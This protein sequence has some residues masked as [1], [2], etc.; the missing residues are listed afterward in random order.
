M[1]FTLPNGKT[2]FGGLAGQASGD[3]TPQEASYL[4]TLEGV[5]AWRYNVPSSVTAMSGVVSYDIYALTESMRFSASGT[6]TVSKGNPIV[7]PSD[8]SSDVWDEILVKLSSLEDTLESFSSFVG[9]YN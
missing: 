1:T 6:F 2:L 8:P 7:S 3:D 9:T 4:L 5:S